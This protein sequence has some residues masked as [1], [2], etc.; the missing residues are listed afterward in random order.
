MHSQ[1]LETE[2]PKSH[3]LTQPYTS[4]REIEER[5]VELTLGARRTGA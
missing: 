5:V 3:P 2:R 1:K 4:K